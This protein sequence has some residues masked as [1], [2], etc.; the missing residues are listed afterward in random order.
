MA[1]KPFSER[2]CCASW[3]SSQTAS[4]FDSNTAP[5]YPLQN[6]EAGAVTHVPAGNL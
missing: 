5:H 2:A 1:L 3:W 6:V 4:V